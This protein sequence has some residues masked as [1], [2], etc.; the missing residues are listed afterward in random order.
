MSLVLIESPNK[1]SKLKDILGQKYKIMA[2]VGHIMDLSKKDL[3]IINLETFEVTYKPNPD[4]KDVIS[5]IKKEIENHDTIYLA[6]DPDREGEAIAF[7]LSKL[8]PDGKKIFRVKFNAITKDVVLKA[9]KNPGKLDEN[10]FLAQKARRI[11]DRVVGFKVSPVMWNKG[12]IGTSAGRV[13]SVAL[14]YIADRE[15]EVKAF[16]PEE[17][18]D[19]VANFVEDFGADVYSVNNKNIDLKTEADA[20]KLED[21]ILKSDSVKVIDVSSKKRSRKPYPPFTTSTLQQS[22]SSAFGWSAKKT[23]DVAQAIFSQ[24]LITYHRTDSVR[25][26]PTKIKDLRD[27]IESQYGKKY[28]SQSVIS[29]GAKDGAQDAHEAIRP[30]YEQPLNQLDKDEKRLLALIDSRFTASQM[31]DAEFDQASLKIEILSGKDSI[32]AKKNGSIMTFDGFLKVY[33]EKQEDVSLPPLK[34]DQLL[35]IK[36]IEKSQH[37][38]KPKPRYTDASIIKILESDGVGRPSTYAAILDT[39]FE[40]DYITRNGNTLYASEIGIM[41]SDYLTANFPKIVDSNFTSTME[42]NLDK[43]ADGSAIYKD[44]LSEFYLDI[45]GQVKGALKCNLPDTFIV[46]KDCP[47][48]NSKM[49]KKISKHGAFL[50]CTKWP[51]CN[52]TRSM[53][54][55]EKSSSD[56]ETGHKCPKCSN[57][58]LKR[59]GKMGKFYGCKSY[60]DCKFTAKIGE[61][62]SPVFLEKDSSKEEV[63]CTKCKKGNMIEK[64]GKFG[65]FYGCSAYPK[66]KNIQKTI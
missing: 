36:N 43:I 3:G 60:P 6:T 11:T 66:C 47:K 16:K 46:E 55:E 4:K 22:A 45:E 58:L 56:V 64:T 44:V 2:S 63:I 26:D 34:K 52:G 32:L 50:G 49:T 8:V 61:D 5:S 51:E 1:V 17:Y 23:M 21:K 39:L 37:F 30:T 14:K 38:T 18:W 40:R 28:L 54:G 29:Y 20:K 9:I 12:L 24:G 53:D 42:K 25:V 27:K 19:M 65:K 33:G 48:C 13:Q 59:D 31:S 41:V 7:H 57:I 15:K 10:L 35:K 62:D